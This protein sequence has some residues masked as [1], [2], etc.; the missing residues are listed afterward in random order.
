MAA[1]QKQILNNAANRIKPG[2]RIVY[3]TCSVEPEENNQI[4]DDF[5]AKTKRF[6]LEVPNITYNNNLCVDV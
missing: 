6:G 2:G 1:A 4:I 5:L 3:S